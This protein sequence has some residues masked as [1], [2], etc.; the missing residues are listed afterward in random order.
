MRQSSIKNYYK[1]CLDLSRLYLRHILY[2]PKYSSP[3]C[4]QIIFFCTFSS[5]YDSL[6]SVLIK[7]TYMCLVSVVILLLG[8][9]V[10]EKLA[11]ILRFGNEHV[12]IQDITQILEPKKSRFSRKTKML[13]SKICVILFSYMAITY[14]FYKFYFSI[15][16]H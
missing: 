5:S 11:K 13:I 15:H 14:P 9:F 3:L 10:W 4:R 2:G 16:V 7:T 1:P 12:H 8:P 6:T